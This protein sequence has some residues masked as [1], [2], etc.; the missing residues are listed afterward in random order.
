M[1]S[2]QIARRSSH[3]A[4]EAD[5]RLP[6]CTANTA[7]IL[8]GSECLRHCERSEA[9]QKKSTGLLR[10]F[11]PRND[12]GAIVILAQRLHRCR[13]RCSPFFRASLEGCATGAGACGH[14]SRRRASARPQSPT[15]KSFQ[16]KSDLAFCSSCPALCRAS[17]SYFAPN[18]KDV[19]GRDKPGHD[20]RFFSQALRPLKMNNH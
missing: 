2:G 6:A 4:P 8:R 5:W 11:A 19:D 1:G 7:V 18:K 20:A 10:R 17:T 14:P 15:G 3:L 16:V 9:I 13:G 12:T